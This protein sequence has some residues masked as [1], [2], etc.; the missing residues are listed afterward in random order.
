MV[1]ITSTDAKISMRTGTGK[2]PRPSA[3]IWKSFTLY[4]RES[5][6]CVGPRH[7]VR[8]C[9]CGQAR[10]STCDLCPFVQGRYHDGITQRHLRP[11]RD[12]LAK[13]NRDGEPIVATAMMQRAEANPRSRQG[14]SAR[15]TW[16]RPENKARKCVLVRQA[17]L[18]DPRQWRLRT[19]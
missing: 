3:K 12:L 6:H 11:R 13:P 7:A 5:F 19:E 16:E 15:A 2:M 8:G 14:S 4:A 1:V 10:R 9:R 17:K 18:V